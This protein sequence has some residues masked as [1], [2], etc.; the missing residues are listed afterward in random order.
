LEKRTGRRR[1]R[2]LSIGLAL[3]CMLWAVGASAASSTTAFEG[4]VNVNTANLAELES[5]PGI[6]PSRAA[7]ILDERKQ[8]GGFHSVEEIGEVRGFGDA[9]LE[10]LRPFITLTGRTTLSM[11]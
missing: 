10:K 8:R 7:A 3:A 11:R 6:G 9:L 2:G 1:A 5:L 4:V